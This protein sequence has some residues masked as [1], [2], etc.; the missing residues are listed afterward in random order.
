MHRVPVLRNALRLKHLIYYL[1]TKRPS[2]ATPDFPDFQHFNVARAVQCSVCNGIDRSLQPQCWRL[3]V[4]DRLG[5]CGIM[6]SY[7]NPLTDYSPQMEFGG[8][9]RRRHFRRGLGNN[10]MP[11]G[12]LSQDDEMQLAADFLDVADEA[13]ME[14]FLGDLVNG[15]GSALGKVVNSPIGQA[16]GGVLK[17]VAKTALPIAGGALGTF[18]GGPIGGMLGSNLA[19]MAGSALGLELEGL[20]PEDQE[21]EATR[22]FIRF[23]G[24]TVANALQADPNA[25]PEAVAHSAAVEAARVHAPGLME[26]A[27]GE[28]RKRGHHTGRWVRHGDKII[29]FGV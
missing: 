28:S 14:Q 12:V 11:S 16:V 5:E 26:I 8:G 1:K 9:S 22:Q 20:S 29:L 19:S 18:V 17:D 24:Q 6:S 4:A 7:A 3:P 15:I 2:A 21:F 27:R 25:D 13:E 23:A 10:A